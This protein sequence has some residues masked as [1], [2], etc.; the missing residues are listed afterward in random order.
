[1]SNVVTRVD[2]AGNIKFDKEKSSEKID[3]AVA[4]VM[5][6]GRAVAAGE[7]GSIYNQRGLRSI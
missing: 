1:V 6:V 4:L 2:P 3:L 5:A 7:H